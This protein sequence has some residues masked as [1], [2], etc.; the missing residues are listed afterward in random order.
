MPQL[1]KKASKTIGVPPGT[2]IEDAKIVRETAITVFDYDAK[3]FQ[4]KKV[5][6]VEE[7]F[8]FKDSST[9]TWVN[10]VGIDPQ[11]IQKI[12]EHFGVHPLVSEDIVSLGQRPKMEDY[13]DYIFIVLKMIYFNEKVNEI[14]D[15]QI[16]LVLGSNFVIS[17][18]EKEGDVFDPIRQRIR[19][20]KGRVRMAGADYLAYTLLDSVIDNY[21]II[22]EKRG[23]ELEDLEDDIVLNPHNKIAQEIHQIKR[24]MIYLKKQIWPLREVISGLQRNESKLIKKQ[25]GIYLRDVYDH[26]IQVMDTIESFRDMLS[27]MHDI[28]LSSVSNRMNEIMKVLT[29]FAAIFIPLTFIAGIYG[30]NFKTDVSSF[31]MPELS[32]KYGY[33]FFW[34]VIL[35]T[36]G[37]MLAFFKRKKWF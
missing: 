2:V 9:V 16:S 13:G 4:E 17:I 33:V 1:F 35:V 3:N 11:T 19:E 34:A 23:E 27:G 8:P 30:M 18:Q 10:I 24:D 14:I 12:D 20:S 28:Y 36:T 31:N 29:I 25:T 15:E 6:S 26:T 21:Y 5:K 32:W 22:L 7:C 37:T